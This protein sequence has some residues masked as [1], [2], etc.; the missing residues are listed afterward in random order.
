MLSHVPE[1]L[2]RLGPAPARATVRTIEQMALASGGGAGPP[3]SMKQ[4]PKPGTRASRGR[5]EYRTVRG[6]LTFR[7][8]RRSRV[9]LRQTPL[10]APT[11]ASA[12]PQER[13]PEPPRACRARSR[14]PTPRA[15]TD[16]RPASQS[17]W[18]GASWSRKEQ[19]PAAAWSRR[20]ASKAMRMTKR[21]ERT[22]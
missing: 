10:P 9:R 3:G 14:R 1:P 12:S 18:Q 22:S 13:T 20:P 17:R 15:A 4:R 6:T 2:P 8:K 19:R 5:D 21:T 16:P 11:M 7:A